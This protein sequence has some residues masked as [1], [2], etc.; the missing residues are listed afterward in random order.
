MEATT[1]LQVQRMETAFPN[2]LDVN[3]LMKKM[4]LQENEWAHLRP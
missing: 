2:R 1:T 3:G 4:A